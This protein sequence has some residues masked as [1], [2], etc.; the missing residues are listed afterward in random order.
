MMRIVVTTFSFILWG[1]AEYG[2]HSVLHSRVAYRLH[3]PHHT[4][5]RRPEQP[6]TIERV[7]VVVVLVP[8]VVAAACFEYHAVFVFACVLEGLACCIMI[9]TTDRHTQ[10]SES[11]RDIGTRYSAPLVKA[12]MIA[13]DVYAKSD[14]ALT[15]S[16]YA[17]RALRAIRV[18]REKCLSESPP[19]DYD[20]NRLQVAATLVEAKP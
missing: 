16:Y 20:S 4:S 3:R 2:V 18:A 1:L 11:R 10:T 17:M 5:P 12:R 9:R 15:R 6:D 13:I 7:V 19:I 8:V 14:G